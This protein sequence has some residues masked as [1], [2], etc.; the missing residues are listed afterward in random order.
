MFKQPIGLS[1]Y[2][3]C[4]EKPFCSH[5]ASPTDHADLKQVKAHGNSD[6]R[7]HITPPKR[8]RTGLGLEDG[9]WVRSWE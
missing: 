1:E 2:A 8:C 6:C 5:F 3:F 4:A 9:N 7:A